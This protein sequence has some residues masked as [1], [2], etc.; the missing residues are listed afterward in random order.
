MPKIPVDIDNLVTFKQEAAFFCELAK[1]ILEGGCIDNLTTGKLLTA[2]SKCLG[3]S[4]FGAMVACNKQAHSYLP[5]SLSNITHFRHF[6]ASIAVETGINETDLLVVASLL[7]LGASSTE[8]IR[9]YKEESKSVDAFTCLTVGKLGFSELFIQT[10]TPKV[11]LGARVATTLKNMAQWL[12]ELVTFL[13]QEM[14]AN[15]DCLILT[16][17]NHLDDVSNLHEVPERLV[18]YLEFVVS[19]PT[20]KFLRHVF[21]PMYSE[22]TLVTASDVYDLVEKDCVEM[23][24]TLSIDINDAIYPDETIITD[25]RKWCLAFFTRLCAETLVV[26]VRIKVAPAVAKSALFEDQNLQKA[27][28]QVMQFLRRNDRVWPPCRSGIEMRQVS[29]QP[30]F[31]PWVQPAVTQQLVKLNNQI[32]QEQQE[33]IGKLNKIEELMINKWVFHYLV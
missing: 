8:H 19:D 7:Q 2:V 6:A 14:L 24:Q 26:D 11:L 27:D 12:P 21:C 18:G 5:I 31:E 28:E 33:L 13:K 17:R 23:E 10:S 30:Y 3:Y 9:F 32:Y 15:D 16:P 1:K 29:N 22:L 20:L 4:S 25:P